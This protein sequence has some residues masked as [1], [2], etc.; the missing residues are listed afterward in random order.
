MGKEKMTKVIREQF[1]AVAVAGH[2]AMNRKDAEGDFL[3]RTGIKLAG[4]GG[5]LECLTA[6]G[7]RLGT[8]YA[9][10]GT[11]HNRRDLA[12]ILKKWQALPDDE[13]KPGAVRVPDPG[14]VAANVRQLAPPAGGLILRTYH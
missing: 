3:R 14:P 10:G 6:N 13:R 1:D 11:E 5:N 9:A 2:V 12:N 8:F 4:A 7:L